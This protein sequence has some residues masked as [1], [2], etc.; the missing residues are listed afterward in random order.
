MNGQ[1]REQDPESDDGR[2]GEQISGAALIGQ[3][4]CLFSAVRHHVVGNHLQDEINPDRDQYQI[5]KVS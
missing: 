4:L 3:S 2:G 5:V 1:Q